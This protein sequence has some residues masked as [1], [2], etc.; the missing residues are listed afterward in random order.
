MSE[1]KKP[2][3]LDQIR[4][5]QA[6]APQVKPTESAPQ[7]PV[8]PRLLSKSPVI[9][10]QVAT[11]APAL[12]TPPEE[13]PKMGLLQAAAAAGAQRK[14]QQDADH[15]YLHTELPTDIK[16]LTTRFDE[17]MCR[18]NG[19]DMLNLG[20]AR[21]YVKKIMVMLKEN[22]EFDNLIIDKDVHNIMAFVRKTRETAVD[23]INVKSAKAEKSA[24]TKASKRNRFGS[25]EAIDFGGSKPMTTLDLEALRDVEF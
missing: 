13:K 7:A 15:A 11:A 12:P 1:E 23:T 9:Q 14:I 20:L 5:K 10:A 16:E 24:A 8:F 18:D 25:I 17:M 2:S 21:A 6:A 3:L 19:I 4:A 22:P